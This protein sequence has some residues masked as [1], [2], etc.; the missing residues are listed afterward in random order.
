M[1]L[2][3]ILLL[4]VAVFT[5]VSLPAAAEKACTQMWCQEGLTLQ[6]DGGTWPAGDYTFTVAMDGAT[7]TC[8]GSLPFKSCDGNVTCDSEDVK[9]GE[10]GC[11]MPANT[12]SFYGVLSQKTPNQLSV[13]I[14]RNDGK[15]FSY[16]SEVKGT[17][18]YPNGPSC[19][20]RQ[21]CSAVVTTPLVWK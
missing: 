15:S 1:S 13:N 14:T 11:A 19:D 20:E 10:S 2:R 21:C 17:C 5:T 18:F 12:H 7:T 3:I 8:K 16:V 9:I 4:F 6:F